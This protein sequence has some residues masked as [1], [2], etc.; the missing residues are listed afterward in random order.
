[1]SEGEYGEMIASWLRK[2][3]AVIANSG[4]ITFFVSFKVFLNR[5]LI[6]LSLLFNF[7]AARMKIFLPALLMVGL[8]DF[9]VPDSEVVLPEWLL[10]TM[11]DSGIVLPERL[12]LTLPVSG[13]VLPE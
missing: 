11:L 5:S 1:M 8:A 6:P 2:G 12:R 4:A 7:A 9:G 13:I 10:L 3:N